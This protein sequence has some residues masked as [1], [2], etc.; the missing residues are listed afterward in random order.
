MNLLV[1]S[2]GFL[3]YV[4]AVSEQPVRLPVSLRL[5]SKGNNNTLLSPTQQ[6]S[7]TVYTQ[8]ADQVLT[9]QVKSL[10]YGMCKNLI[11]IA[12]TYD[13]TRPNAV[14]HLNGDMRALRFVHSGV[15]DIATVDLKA[16]VLIL[17]DS[18]KIGLCYGVGGAKF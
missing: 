6:I 7:L 11:E 13:L 16:A 12:G 8:V 14:K 17:K 1:D 3:E 10:I 15:S 2:D 9:D 5:L 4:D 18:C